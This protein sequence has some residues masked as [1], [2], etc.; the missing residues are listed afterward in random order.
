MKEPEIVPEHLSNPV[1]NYVLVGILLVGLCLFVVLN[2]VSE[3]DAGI[4]AFSTSVIIATGVAIFAFVVSKQSETGILAKSYFLLGLGF[5]S[6]VVAELP[7]Y[8]FDLVLGIE[9]YPS[10]A[11]LFFFALYPLILGHLLLNL[12]YFHMGYSNFQKFWII[13][14]PVTALVGLPRNH[15]Y[16]T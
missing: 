5:T 6:Y 9:A 3:D 15:Q 16:F 1:N 10:I 13:A 12:K 11:D 4:I 2:L 8:T 7:Y 14:I